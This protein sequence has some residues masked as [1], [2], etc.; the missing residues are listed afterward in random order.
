MLV[1]VPVGH[2]SG[3]PASPAWEGPTLS[4]RQA[5]RRPSATNRRDAADF[6]VPSLVMAGRSPSGSRAARRS[7]RVDTLAS[8][9]WPGGRA[10][11]RPGPPSSSA[12]RPQAIIAAH[13]QRCTATLPPWKPILPLAVPHRWP[14]RGLRRGYAVRRRAAARPRT[15]PVSWLRSRSCLPIVGD[16]LRSSVRDTHEAF[17]RDRRVPCPQC[18]MFGQRWT[19][20]KQCKPSKLAIYISNHTTCTIYI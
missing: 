10:S 5:A 16:N 17:V 18:S 14:R 19:S 11:L 1:A 7:L 8:G 20:T 4:T 2:R 13:P 3:S 15:A 9:S 6:E 12:A